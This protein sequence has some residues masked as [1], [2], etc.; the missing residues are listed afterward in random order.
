MKGFVITLDS[1]IAIIVAISLIIII[2]APT[3]RVRPSAWSGVE[4][5]R[6]SMDSL[7]IL[8]KSGVLARA[9]QTNSTSELLYFMSTESTSLCMRIRIS[10]SNGYG[11]YAAKAGCTSEA[12]GFSLSKRSF[13]SGGKPYIAEM[14]SWEG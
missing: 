8:Q 1:V 12:S 13:I 7:A 5:K 10:G 14:H 3:L 11:L 2:S 6:F 4:A 9:V